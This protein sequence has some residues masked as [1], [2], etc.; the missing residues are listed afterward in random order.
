MILTDKIG[1]LH[2]IDKYSFG[3]VESVIFNLIENFSSKK[4]NL[5][6]YFLRDLGNRKKISGENITIGNYS[7]FNPFALS[8]LA[9]FIKSN[10]IK[11]IHTHHRKGF[12]LAFILSLFIKFKWVHHEHGDILINNYFYKL[13]V[14]LSK[15][16]IDLFIAVSKGVYE[17]LLASKVSSKKINLLYNSVDLSRFNKKNNR[18]NFKSRREM[19]GLKK[20][21]FV[22]G[23]VG[24][25]N[26]VKGCI[27]LIK[28]LTY[29]DF[30]YK[31]IICGDG[32]EKKR[33]EALVKKLNLKNNVI[34]LGYISNPEKIY[35]LLDVLVIPSLSESFG[36]SALEGASMGVKIIGTDIPGLRE[37]LSWSKDILFKAKN[38]KD[39][40]DK[41]LLAKSNK[42]KSPPKDI[43]F[44]TRESFLK[45]LENLYESL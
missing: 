16:K 36:L 7:K 42:I 35:P 40:A 18:F 19:I 6:F 8:K 38:P 17:K 14:K 28:S 5:Y 45:S 32:P 30:E 33:L 37:V 44:Q 4:F 25:L 31:L 29:L 21:D 12:Y 3:G 13:I 26:K 41:L 23:F 2:I 24:R 39:I 9:Q 43:V 15:K 22:I 27:Y 11:I 34:F 1:V 20:E 10:K